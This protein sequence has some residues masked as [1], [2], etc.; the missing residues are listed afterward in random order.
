MKVL[1]KEVNP[2]TEYQGNISDY[3]IIVQLDSG[4]NIELFDAT[5]Y[6]LRNKI[7]Q[8][9]ECL[10]IAT[11][12]EI[13]DEPDQINKSLLTGKF[14][15]KYV[16]SDKWKNVF[17]GGNRIYKLNSEWYA[18]Y[19]DDGVFLVTFSNKDIKSLKEGDK[20]NL[21]VGRYDLVAWNPIKD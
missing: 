19:S 13:F 15:G 9:L 4:Q 5:P 1:I 2:G 20:V 12:V 11:F 16:I 6:D 7:N 10:I 8:T 17:E 14:L 21:T 18:I 3:W